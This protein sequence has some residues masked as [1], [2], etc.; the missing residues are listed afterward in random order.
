MTTVETLNALAARWADFMVHGLFDATLLGVVVALLWLL[1]RRWASAQVGILPLPVGDSQ[2]LS[3]NPRYRAGLDDLVVAR[4]YRRPDA[5]RIVG[6]LCGG[7][8]CR[9]GATR[10]RQN[11]EESFASMRRDE[12]RQATAAGGVSLGM[13]FAAKLMLAWAAIVLSL[14]A[15]FGQAQWRTGRQF[16]SAKPLDP[17]T[18]A[19]DVERTRATRR[20]ARSFAIVGESRGDV[21]HPVENDAAAACLAGGFRPLL[22]IPA[23]CLAAVARVRASASPRLVGSR[24]A[25]GGA[26]LALFQSGR[27]AGQLDDRPAARIRLRRRRDGRLRVFPLRLRQGVLVG[28]RARQRNVG[29][30]GRHSRLL[31]LPLVRQEAVAANPGFA[32]CFRPHL[33]A[34]AAIL[35]L[36]AAS[37]FLPRFRAEKA[38]QRR[39]AAGNSGAIRRRR[40]NSGACRAGNDPRLAGVQLLRR[41]RVP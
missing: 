3:A 38:K 36:A 16:R 32:A 15:R 40:L 41:L 39:A 27:M 17:T 21:A 24:F 7:R 5:G 31:R 35:L 25:A 33:S 2:A 12:N 14:F 30:R 8:L 22:D 6:S 9:S 13:S 1:L 11:D 34:A 29:F 37:V 20:R 4:A 28:R 10:R 23:S 26:S 18:M 19:V